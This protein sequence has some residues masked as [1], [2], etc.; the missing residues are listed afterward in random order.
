MIYLL[1]SYNNNI[2]NISSGFNLLSIKDIIIITSGN[3]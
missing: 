1:K 3:P 2:K